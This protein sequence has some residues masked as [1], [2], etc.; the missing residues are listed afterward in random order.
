MLFCFHV[1][2]EKIEEPVCI[3]EARALLRNSENAKS[4][5]LGKRVTPSRLNYWD[6]A[7]AIEKR[8]EEFEAVEVLSIRHSV[9]S[10]ISSLPP[11]SGYEAFRLKL[12]FKAVVGVDSQNFRCRMSV[13]VF[14][15]LNTIP[16]VDIDII[17]CKNSQ[18]LI[19]E[20]FTIGD[21]VSSKIRKIKA[22]KS[23]V[24]RD[25]FMTKRLSIFCSFNAFLLLR[26]C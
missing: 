23:V 21:L 19:L 12:R 16:A 11:K 25:P 24:E 8:F 1:V 7:L 15:G 6:L 20:D 17:N 26:C 5:Y 22:K 9:D 14:S 4:F 10:I 18:G 2:A 13:F 3:D